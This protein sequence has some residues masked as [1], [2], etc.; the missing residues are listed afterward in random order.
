[1]AAR[2]AREPRSRADRNG[3]LAGQAGLVIARHF[4][5]MDAIRVADT[6]A[7]AAVPKLPG[8]NAP[9]I[10]AHIPAMGEVIDKL[11]SAG[12]N[13]SEPITEDAAS[14]PLAGRVIVVTRGMNGA[15]AGRNRNDVKELIASRTRQPHPSLTC[16][17]GTSPPPRP[18]ANTWATSRIFRSR[19]GSSSISR[20]SWTASAARSSAGPCPPHAHQPGRRR[21]AD[22]SQTTRCRLDGAVFHSDHGTQ[23]GSGSSPASATNS[24]SHGRWA[25]S[26][27]APT[28]QPAKASAPP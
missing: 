28:A 24:G 14:G 16:S 3:G 4:I 22:G 15:L 23:Y 26:A 8:A 7:L 25:R 19:T 18:G 13:M 21:T 6:D 17:S 9:K 11:T 1:M 27:P 10:A 5:T 12:V 2:R 20:P